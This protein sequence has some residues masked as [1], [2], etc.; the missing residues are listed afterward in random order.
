MTPRKINRRELLK[1][2]GLGILALRFP[3]LGLGAELTQKTVVEDM[4]KWVAALK[5][6]ELP[7][8]IV[9]KAKRVL[10]DTLGC[11]LGAVDAGPVRVA[12]QVVSLRGGNQIGRAH[13]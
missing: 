12:Q 1:G 6:D 2:C 4:A 7:P 3:A 5:Y 9:A 13:V 10:L 11:A 8:E